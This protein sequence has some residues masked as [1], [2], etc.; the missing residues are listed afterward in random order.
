LP[1]E[2]ICVQTALTTVEITIQASDQQYPEVSHQA[3]FK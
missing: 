1:A 2:M 3:G